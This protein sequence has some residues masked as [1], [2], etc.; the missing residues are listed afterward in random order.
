MIKYKQFILIP[1]LIISLAV[2]NLPALLVMAEEGEAT[3]E[4]EE[5]EISYVVT[6]GAQTEADVE[7]IVN[8]NVTDLTDDE[9][10]EIIEEEVVEEE[11]VEEEIVEEEEIIEEETAEEEETIE[12]EEVVEEEVVEEDE[13]NDVSVEV[14]NDNEAVI[15]NDVE[16]EANTGGNS[17][18]GNDNHALIDTGDAEAVANISNVANTNVVGS[19]FWFYLSNFFGDLMGDVHFD[20]FW[21]DGQNYDSC[22]L[23][24]CVNPLEVSNNNQGSITNNV[25]LYA[26]TGNNSAD[27]NYG[28]S[29]I[30]TGR[31]RAMVNVSNFL[32][33]NIVGSDWLMSV[34]N[35]FG[36]WQG[37]LVFP[38]TEAVDEII[39]GDEAEGNQVLVSNDNEAVV[40]NNV[41]VI[42]DTGSNSADGNWGGALIETGQAEAEA[43]IS[44]MANTNI[45]GSNWL[46][47]AVKVF[48]QWDGEI[49]K[50]SLP[51][52]VSWLRTPD[53]VILF[54]D[55]WDE[56][57]EG[58]FEEDEE[59]ITS[60]EMNNN[61]FGEI[62]NNLE[63]VASSGN[64]SASG[65]GGSG[66][67][68]TGDA[69]AIANI[70]NFVNTNII[71]QN[72]LMGLINIFGDWQGN[73]SF[74][75]PNLWLGLSAVVPGG[76][77]YPGDIID[78]TISYLNAGDAEATDVTLVVDYD[79]NPF[80]GS[81]LMMENMGTGH[82]GQSGQISWQIDSI[83]VGGS[84]SVTYSLEVN[85]DISVGE[86]QLNNTAQ[87]GSL[88]DD[89]DGQDN[90]DILSLLINVVDHPWPTAGPTEGTMGAKEGGQGS[91]DGLPLLEISKTNDTEGF[92][93]PDE[94]I[95]YKIVLDNQGDGSAYDVVVID[96]FT[97]N[98]SAEIIETNSWQLGEVFPGEEII[99]DYSLVINGWGQAGYYTNTVQADG[100]DIYGQPISSNQAS[101][102]V[103]LLIEETAGQE[104]GGGEEETEDL[105]EE[106]TEPVPLK[107][108]IEEQ[109]EEIIEQ[110]AY[111]G[112]G[113]GIDEAEAGGL[114]QIIE[115]EI[116][117]EET[118]E[119]PK[120]FGQNF[121]AAMVGLFQNGSLVYVL[122]SLLGLII[123]AILVLIYLR[124]RN[125][126]K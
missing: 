28:H 49:F 54:N 62:I 103:E 109:I 122:S 114:G 5:P 15:E 107:E 95:N 23:I 16:G 24:D 85:P 121:L 118:E 6:G 57:S 100:F 50:S 18:C 27:G 48:G 120:G 105:T 4:S 47:V 69:S 3:T 61:N 51:E 108:V 96:N 77:P 91:G 65:N 76:S 66:E 102:T 30:N 88:E 82:N 112:P 41:E 111:S 124:F 40:E 42:A 63:V 86:W 116:L 2:F 68:N 119:E 33:T 113:L 12:E 94:L 20:G 97:Y 80:C 81:C 38:G 59:E 98:G 55:D 29:F 37:N 10:E 53:G 74:G 45:F 9:E 93:S 101:T 87:I 32:N 79:N 22:G 70:A 13:E 73:L 19:N 89:A 43:N 99:I 72:W 123:L 78:Y 110:V 60:L 52:G 83:P 35:S 46:M 8:T 44:T 67:I 58:W 104:T 36:N 1:I 56:S 25:E 64:N 21:G 14:T 84:G 126:V 26:L 31:A 125:H 90:S 71:G 7:N 34:F 106:E 115:E 117:E 75:Q 39:N 11:V 92:V 17:V